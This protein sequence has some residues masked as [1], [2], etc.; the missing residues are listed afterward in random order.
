MI[1]A[2]FHIH[3][4]YCDGKSTLE[5]MVSAAVAAGLTSIG[6]A[7]HM[8]LP[9]ANDWTMDEAKL[10]RYRQEVAR[11][12]HKYAAVIEIY[13]GLEIDYFIDRHDISKRAK[14]ILPKLDYTILSIHTIGTTT[15]DDVSYIDDTR[16]DFASGIKKYYDNQ[17]QKFI[18]AYYRGIGEM[19]LKYQPDI[20]G[21]IDLI[22]KYN[23]DN[24][25]FDENEVWYREAVKQCLNTIAKTATRM[26]INTGANMRVPGVGRYPSDWMIPEMQ[27]RGIPITIGGDTHSADGIDFGFSEAELFLLDCGYK[28][29]WMLKNSRWE[30][31]ALG[32]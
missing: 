27:K 9:F 8:P 24:F 3:S 15:G 23:Q 19:V 7:S 29:Y 10:D 4:D 11:L 28:E 5:E 16:D 32:V 30:A 1:Q 12:K 14:E 26:E 25:F 2:N 21:H 18:E 17:P 13:C 31:Q 22:K 20:L 6:F